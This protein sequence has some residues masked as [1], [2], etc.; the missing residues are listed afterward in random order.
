MENFNAQLTSGVIANSIFVALYAIGRWLQSRLQNSDCDMNCGCLS[1]HSELSE[2]HSIKEHI[3][4]TQRLQSGMLRKIVAKM[5]ADGVVP[6]PSM[7]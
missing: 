7:V 4:Q 3:H 6:G 1:C 5:N 2:L